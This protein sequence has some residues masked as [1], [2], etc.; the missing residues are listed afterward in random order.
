M[1]D[2]FL[3]HIACPNCKKVREYAFPTTK[4]LAL[5]YCKE[6]R[7]HYRMTIRPDRIVLVEVDWDATVRLASSAKDAVEN[8]NKC[9]A[10]LI[11]LPEPHNSWEEEALN[12]IVSVCENILNRWVSR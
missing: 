1:N 4:R 2:T 7:T 12:E 5:G 8:L 6:C 10:D 11:G 9:Y 3:K